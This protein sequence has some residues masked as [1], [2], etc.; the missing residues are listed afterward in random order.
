MKQIILITLYLLSKLN[1]FI[2]KNFQRKTPWLDGLTG[3]FYKMFK[4]ELTP[5]LNNLFQNMQKKTLPSS[6]YKARITLIPKSD[7]QYNKGKGH[8]NILH[9][10]RQ[11]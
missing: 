10:Y 3:E 2:I 5:V 8:I 4:E 11:K 1:S 6:F 9:K 7:R